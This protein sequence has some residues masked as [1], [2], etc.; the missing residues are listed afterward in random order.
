M[1]SGPFQHFFVS[2]IAEPRT[3]RRPVV[4]NTGLSPSSVLGS[5]A[6]GGASFM[7]MLAISAIAM[8]AVA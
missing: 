5:K 7:Q 4:S 1:S 3:M 6:F 8:Q 2:G